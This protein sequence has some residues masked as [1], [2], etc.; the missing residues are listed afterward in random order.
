MYTFKNS[1]FIFYSKWFLLLFYCIK[2]QII[3][4]RHYS[5][6]LKLEMLRISVKIWTFVTSFVT[7]WIQ[8]LTKKTEK[9]K[10]R[11]HKFLKDKKIEL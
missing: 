2:I 3:H 10:Y 7:Q 5:S 9:N 11:V 8:E 4:S 6:F 1:A